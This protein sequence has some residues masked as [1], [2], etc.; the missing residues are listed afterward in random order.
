M[1]GINN[2]KKNYLVFLFFYIK[3]VYQQDYV[4]LIKNSSLFQTKKVFLKN[5]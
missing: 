3:L 2:V 1:H 4:D 5:V